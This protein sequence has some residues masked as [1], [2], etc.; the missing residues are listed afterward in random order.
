MTTTLAEFLPAAAARH[1]ERTA[2]VV[3]ERRL[4]FRELDAQSNRVA[5]GLAALG[6]KP[7]DR[8]GLFGANSCEWVVCYY[9]I[10]KTGAVL[11]PL[12]SMLTTDELR[13][14]VTD[15]GARV[16]IGA[17]DKAG[18]LHELKTAG[19][20][21]HVV[22]WGTGTDEAGDA[23]TLGDWLSNCDTEFEV[24]TR[25][26]SDLAVIAYTSGTTGR[27]KGAMQSHR[28]VLAAAV[29]TALMAARTSEDRIVSALPLFHVYGSCVMNAAM[30]AGSMLIT[31]PRFSEVAMLSAIATHRA[32]LMDGVPT[33]YYYLLAHPDFDRYDLSSL[34]LCWVGGQTLPAA[35][36]LEF[37]RRTG[38][39]V[40]EVW[41]MTE[42][43]GATSA[44]PVYGHNKPGTI[45]LPYPGNAF[46]VVD[47]EDATREMP[48]GQ[49]GELM[50]SGPLVMLG[51]HNN[52]AATAETVRP[53]GWLHTGDIAIM[54]DDGYA[55]IVDRKKDMILTA[56]F[57]VY[58]AELER[59]LC[60][61]P[62]VALAAVGS[63]PDEAKGELAKAYVILRPGAQVTSASL[64]AHCREHLAAYKVPR[65]VQFVDSV[66]MTPSGKIM[67]R[68]LK[69]IDDGKRSNESHAASQTD[70]QAACYSEVPLGRGDHLRSARSAA[71]GGAPH[72]RT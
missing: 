22:L 42:L 18:Q 13:Y 68:M 15:A 20:L 17:S 36:S 40:H 25:Q 70:N 10:A 62:A 66:P 63:I 29:G 53:D 2:L 59:I 57:N 72:S 60:M 49:P 56:G 46:R 14:T 16:A 47:M 33:A 71:L 43:A 28:A 31:L 7:G 30:L 54:D 61:H 12:S 6:V 35:K 67:R 8:V 5:N 55:T 9:G 51:Y 58:P 38:C 21:D 52:A 64:I 65:A 26:P 50:Y 45:G 37:T 19:V 48:R 1:A 44:N 69:S 4:S 23:T 24:R 11:N 39:P 3:D 32:T 27:P 41:G 34:R